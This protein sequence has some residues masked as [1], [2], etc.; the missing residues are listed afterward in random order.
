MPG[1][2]DFKSPP[3]PGC[4]GGGCAGP[5]SHGCAGGASSGPPLPEPQSRADGWAQSKPWGAQW[6][7][8][9]PPFPPFLLP[10]AHPDPTDPWMELSRKSLP[11]PSQPSPLWPCWVQVLPW[12]PSPPL[13]GMDAHGPLTCPLP[14]CPGPCLPPG[15]GP[16]RSLGSRAWPFPARAVG[17]QA[18]CSS[19][20]TCSSPRPILEMRD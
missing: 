4:S 10:T 3:G 17:A 1:P 12:D 7:L 8:L 6:G 2:T 15:P 18:W 13:C 19:R 14:R 11:F 20:G 9:G 16:G 5:P